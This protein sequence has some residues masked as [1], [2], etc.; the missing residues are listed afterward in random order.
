MATRTELETII[1]NIYG[2]GATDAGTAAGTLL[3]ADYLDPSGGDLA[4]TTVD[5]ISLFDNGSKKVAVAP[6]SVVLGTNMLAGAYFSD[7]V[8]NAAAKTAGI[9]GNDFGNILIGNAFANKIDAGAGN[10][11]LF[12]GGGS[13]SMKGGDGDDTLMELTGNNTLEGGAGSDTINGGSG[14]NSVAGGDGDDTIIV[15]DGK[16]T[17]LAGDG[18]NSINV[19]VGSNKI[20]GGV[21]NDTIYQTYD[22]TSEVG[23][24]NTVDLGSGDD[25]VQLDRGNATVQGGAGNDQIYTATTGFAVVDGGDGNDTIVTGSMKDTI[26]GGIGNDTINSGSGKDV[27]Y[28]EDGDDLIIT[29]GYQFGGVPKPGN[30]TIYGGVGSDTIKVGFGGSNGTFTGKMNSALVYADDAK[31]MVGGNDV[32]KLANNVDAKSLYTVYTYRGND[33]I[34]GYNGNYKLYTGYGDDSVSVLNGTNTIVTDEA[35]DKVGGADSVT[36]GNGNNKIVTGAGADDITLGSGNNTLDAG[37]GDDFIQGFPNGNNTIVTDVLSDKVGGSDLVLIGNGDNVIKTGAGD[38]AVSMGAGANTIDLGS[39][40]DVVG[41]VFNVVDAAGVITKILGNKIM[42]GDGND[43]IDLQSGETDYAVIDSETGDLLSGTVSSS[44]DLSHAADTIDGGKGD[45]ILY[46]G[47]GDDKVLGG[48]GNDSLTGGT[49]AD[50]LTGGKGHDTFIIGNDGNSTDTITDFK[51]ASTKA[52]GVTTVTTDELKII[53][54][55]G[56]DNVAT[57]GIDE[58]LKLD[59]GDFTISHAASPKDILINFTDG[60]SVLLTKTSLDDL[61]YDSDLGSFYLAD[62]VGGIYTGGTYEDGVYLVGTKTGDFTL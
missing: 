35:K 28:G 57:A 7:A 32:V 56:T 9:N 13:D 31:D 52:G 5:L 40:G 11:V 37:L 8:L 51:M 3:Y 21:G 47:A 30:A 20:V 22:G 12:G 25:Y 43:Y 29:R 6:K 33:S 53:G 2:A 24:N 26:H 54:H 62:G 46:S 61:V 45:D 49:G 48:D 39:G 55:F 27:I 17:I 59:T 41:R 4:L 14:N 19:G 50:T 1:N 10:D 18:N 44:M 23:G 36:V 38:D 15:G 60:G 16:N 42:A 58:S 34:N